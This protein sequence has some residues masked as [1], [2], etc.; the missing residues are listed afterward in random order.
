MLASF[1]S[2][3][4]LL[5]GYLK[6]LIGVFVFMIAI[7]IIQGNAYMANFY[8]A[9]MAMY[10]PFTL[11]SLGEQS[12]WESM[13]L[14]APVTRS[15]IVGGRYFMCL[16]IDLISLLAG[17]AVSMFIEPQAFVENLSALLFTLILVLTLNAILLPLIYKFGTHKSRFVIMAFCL[18]P[19]LALPISSAIDCRPLAHAFV[20]LLESL[21]ALFVLNLAALM[22]LSVSYLISRAI[23]HRKEF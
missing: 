1:K 17:F 20:R 22:L 8:S 13:L 9:F 6:T 7:S 19:A 5:R 15:A 10:M 12:G 23:Y 16:V 3:F 14:S 11:A 18:L 4:Y 2:D 21:P